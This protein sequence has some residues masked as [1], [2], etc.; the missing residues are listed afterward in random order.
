MMR[1]KLFG[2]GFLATT[3]HWMLL[4]LYYLLLLTPMLTPSFLHS[5]HKCKS[6]QSL[7]P[8]CLFE[9]AASGA[10]VLAIP[11]PPTKGQILTS[12]VRAV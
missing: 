10:G 2:F 8:P 12:D 9:E 7:A 1:G 5:R 6:D 3:E 11:P 4:W